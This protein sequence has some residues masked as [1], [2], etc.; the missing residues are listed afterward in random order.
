MAVRPTAEFRVRV[1]AG[2]GVE[3]GGGVVVGGDGELVVEV[4]AG[5]VEGA[6]VGALWEV[7]GREATVEEVLELVAFRGKPRQGEVFGDV[8]EAEKATEQDE[9]QRGAVVSDVWDL[10]SAIEGAPVDVGDLDGGIGNAA[11]AGEPGVDEAPDQ[12]VRCHPVTLM[13]LCVLPAGE[14]AGVEADEGEPGGVGRREAEFEERLLA[15]GEMGNPEGPLHGRKSMARCVWRYLTREAYRVDRGAAGGTSARIP[16]GHRTSRLG[17]SSYGKIG[18]VGN[19]DFVRRAVN[20]LDEA[21]G[22]VAE[23]EFARL[24]DHQAPEDCAEEIEAAFGSLGRLQSAEQPDEPAYDEWDTLFYVSWYQPRQVHL[25]SSVVRQLYPSGVPGPLHVVDVGCGAWAVQMA[26]A[27]V[28]GEDRLN[29][30]DCPVTVHGIDSSGHMRRLGEELWVEWRHCAAADGRL[31]SLV[32]TMDAMSVSC[33][34]YD[35]YETWRHS[36][37]LRHT[38]RSGVQRWLTAVH[39][40]Y[41]ARL[42]ELGDLYCEVWDHLSDLSE[43]GE[44]DVAIA[45]SDGSKKR[46]VEELTDEEGYE[47]KPDPIWCG[48]ASHT[49]AWRRSLR[50]RLE[51]HLDAKAKNYLQNAVKWDY[52]HNPIKRDAARVVLL[53]Q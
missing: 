9:W 1:A 10:E 52:P 47:L 45:T 51:S 18:H 33:G 15:A 5:V 22:E 37:S 36:A 4:A 32:D 39:A 40:V 12:A 42:G 28:A 53:G 35:S 8:I 27:I 30:S 49:T 11:L 2:V 6:A 21:I 23:A 43:S 17:R 48:G 24:S 26:L 25:V 16:R 50:D 38:S 19:G 20:A 31:G 41:E 13:K 3:E 14:D 44:L 7:E 29:P 46:L 34:A